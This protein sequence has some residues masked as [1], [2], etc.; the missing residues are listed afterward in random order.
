MKK[1]S[2]SVNVKLKPTIKDI[3]AETLKSAINNLLSV[4][5]LHC[6]VNTTYNIEFEANSKTE[7]E[8]IVKTIADEILA[9]SVIEE[10]KI[11]W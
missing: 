5:N 3:K 9:N 4:N 10:Y 2:A 7:A 6:K 1:F 11:K 8:K